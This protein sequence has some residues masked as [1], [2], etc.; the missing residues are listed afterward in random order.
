LRLLAG[1]TLLKNT[2][3][4]FKSTYLYLSQLLQQKQDGKWNYEQ[5]NCEAPWRRNTLLTFQTELSRAVS[6]FIRIQ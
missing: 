1:R 3:S 5:R 4:R 2:V 6:L